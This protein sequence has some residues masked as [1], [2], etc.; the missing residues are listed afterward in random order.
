MEVSARARVILNHIST[1][2]GGEGDWWWVFSK[3][4]PPNIE[5]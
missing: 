1:F 5:V 2:F 4:P 3:Y